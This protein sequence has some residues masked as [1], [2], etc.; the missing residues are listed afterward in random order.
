MLHRAFEDSF[1]DLL[2]TWRRY[3]DAHEQGEPLIEI[4]G[5]RRELDER[6]H[7]ARTIRRLI[8][9]EGDELEEVAFA[10]FCASLET[11]VFI[12]HNGFSDGGYE[13]AC[14]QFVAQEA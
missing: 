7:R 10:A 13:C 1:A 3:R 12:P 5:L 11:T 4:A 14:G 9:P 6:R 8:A 2:A